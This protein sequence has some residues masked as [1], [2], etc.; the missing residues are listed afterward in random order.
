[1]K[2]TNKLFGMITFIVGVILVFSLI[3]CDDGNELGNGPGN[4]PGTTSNAGEAIVQTLTTARNFFLQAGADLA[5][6]SDN[7]EAVIVDAGV[8]RA[9]SVLFALSFSDDKGGGDDGGNDKAGFT[10]D[11][12]EGYMLISGINASIDFYFGAPNGQFAYYLSKFTALEE[13]FADSEETEL[14]DDGVKFKKTANGYDIITPVYGTQ[15]GNKDQIEFYYKLSITTAANG[16]T[17]SSAKCDANGGPAVGDLSQEYAARYAF[18]VAQGKAKLEILSPDNSVSFRLEVIDAADG[19]Y[20]QYYTQSMDIGGGHLRG[21]MFDRWAEYM[22][23]ENVMLGIYPLP[24][25]PYI[26]LRLTEDKQTG[27]MKILRNYETDVRDF[28][29][30]QNGTVPF[31]ASWFASFDKDAA[32]SFDELPLL[33]EGL[34]RFIGTFNYHASGLPHGP[35][36]K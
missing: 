25:Q 21:E 3:G 35:E 19:S 5:E 13:A 8:Q 27:T 7:I 6:M 30:I 34:S 9:A 24:N 11:D 28:V 10:L 12:L 22:Q 29:S 20:I 15:E 31:P 2:T 26:R 18:S 17:T 33:D 32:L 14:M 36:D 16:I 4:G 1:M 23:S